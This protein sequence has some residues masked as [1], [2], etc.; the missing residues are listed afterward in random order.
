MH[1]RAFPVGDHDAARRRGHRE[2]ARRGRGRGRAL[3]GLAT[4]DDGSVVAISDNA[5]AP[6]RIFTIDADARPAVITGELPLTNNGLP[7]GYDAEGIAVREGGYWVVAEGAPADGLVNLLV[8]VDADGAVL[9]EITLP[10]SVALGATS[11]G[12]EGVTVVGDAV[13]VAVQREWADDLPGQVKLARFT[14]STGAWD[15]VA[16]PLDAAP[17]GATVGLSEITAVDDDTVLILERDNRRGLD[18]EI[19][20]IT[21]VELGDVTPVPAGTPLPVVTKGTV[22]DLLPALR[23]GGG[24]VADKPEGVTVTDDGELLVAVDNDG[25]DNAPGESVL[26][27]LGDLPE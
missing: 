19:K 27:R 6:T 25:L 5:Y 3:S 21:R 24:V 22:I 9:R 2:R 15:F 14:P 11:N 4:A 20:K 12:F 7:V 1:A 13:W 17:A 23:A 10:E 8:E 26:L 18:A 16:Y